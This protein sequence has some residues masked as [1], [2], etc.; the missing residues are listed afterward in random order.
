MGVIP[1]NSKLHFLFYVFFFWR[2]ALFIFRGYL[3][4][5]PY[6]K[7]SLS[8]EYVL[9]KTRPVQF[10]SG[11]LAIQRIVHEGELYFSQLMRTAPIRKSRP[12]ITFVT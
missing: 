2:R 11:F 10:F 12:V 6:K 8:W 1:F 4:R 7:F 3:T 5:M 9:F